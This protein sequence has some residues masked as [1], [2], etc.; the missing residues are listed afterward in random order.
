MTHALITVDEQS[1][2]VPIDFEQSAASNKDVSRRTGKDWVTATAEFQHRTYRLSKKWPDDDVA[3]W[4]PAAAA[5]ATTTS[6]KSPAA[7]I[8]TRTARSPSFRPVYYPIRLALEFYTGCWQGHATLRSV[9]VAS[10]VYGPNVTQLALPAFGQLLA[11][12]LTAPFFLFQM[13]CVV[14]WS[15]DEYW[16]YALYTLGAL[17]VFESTVAYNRLRGLERLRNAGHSGTDRVWVRR[18]TAVGEESDEAGGKYPAALWVPVLSK[19]LVPGDIVSLS[20]G[21]TIPADI[22]L[23]QGSGV[24]DEAPLTGESTPQL[25]HELESEAPT[26]A[27]LAPPPAPPHPAPTPKLDLQDAAHKESVLFGGT[28]LLAVTATLGESEDGPAASIEERRFPSLP[29]QGLVGMVVRTGFETS[30]GSLL[31]TLSSSSRKSD[32]VHTFDAFAFILGLVVCALAAAGWVWREAYGDERRNPFRLLLHLIILITSV[33]PPEL[34]MELSLAVTNSVAAL[35]QRHAVYCTE[36]FRIPLA[37]QVNV[38]C[39]DKT[40]TITSDEMRLRGVRLI[41]K[42]TTQPQPPIASSSGISLSPALDSST[43]DDKL[44]L[45]VSSDES[46]GESAL[47]PWSTLRVMA[48][49]HALAVG[50]GTVR[51]GTRKSRAPRFIGDPLEVAVLKHTGF[52]LVGNDLVTPTSRVPLPAEAKSLSILHRFSFSSKLKRMTTLVVEGNGQ[53]GS[54]WALCKG[55]PETVKLLLKRSS[56]PKNYDVISLYHMSRGRRVLSM[57]YKKL[58]NARD[59][60]NY[61]NSGRNT[62]ERDLVFAG[63]LIFDCPLKPESKAVISELRKSGQRV[64]MITGDALL[65]AAE[66]ARQVGIIG[67]AAGGKRLYQIQRRERTEKLASDDVLKDFECVSVLP[68]PGEMP[69]LELSR[70]DLPRLIAMERDGQATFCVSGEV[71]TNISV[72][73]ARRGSPFSGI[74]S[75]DERHHLMHPN[76]LSVL[77]SIVPMISVYARH[78]PHQKEA[79]VAAY[80]RGGFITCMCGDGTNDVGALKR[81]HV[82]ISIVN[83]PDAESKQRNATEKLKLAKQ[84]G[85]ANRTKVAE[86]MRELRDAQE[87]LDCVELG[88]ASVAAPFTSRQVSIKCC[89]DVIQQGRCTLVSMLSIYKI[90]GVNCLVNAMVLSKLFLHGAKQGERQLTILGI[91]V[92]ALFYFVTRAEPLP[93]LS[94]IRPPSS[95]LC[96]E[97]LLSIMGQLV[98]HT[99]ATLIATDAALAFADSYDPSLTP[100][101]SFNPNALNS[102][103]F[104]LTGLASIN[105]FAVNY[106]GRPFMADLKSNRLLYRTLQVCYGTL[107]ACALEVFPPLNDLLQLAS[108]AT[109]SSR[110]AG[111]W[112]SAPITNTMLVQVVQVIDFPAFLSLLM[113]IDTVIVF[114]LELYLVTVFEERRKS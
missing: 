2:I 112:L 30:Q 88:D 19:E 48:A 31:R 55:A 58:D 107:F 32:G 14:L 87:Q 24:V 40:G 100:D 34:P 10:R 21:S 38:C 68:A 79:I 36:P 70:S 49:C 73:S 18:G 89:K 46:S 26:L 99:A 103:T 1:G 93:T 9:Q 110:K 82:G 3:L 105:T 69:S 96:A 86:S 61:K 92:A 37:G 84:D 63:F 4:M 71:L 64:V 6:V 50:R 11:E 43:E 59:L 7:V 81:A 33:V 20:S 74:P 77:E 65:T 113:L 109:V 52:E 41:T 22:V 23:L 90:L 8:E 27:G 114:A 51:H 60:V 62:V 104:L 57:A 53:N 67:K 91:A 83:A 102:C 42:T 108:L 25:K 76:T 54:L 66:V 72:A 13:L 39:L 15:L 44:I 35:M 94:P 12:Q 28:T 75:K 16:I 5:T 29:N 80:N 95:I 101:G 56:V 111:H 78:A 85:A 106:R 45:P 98:V 17:L 97:A 47:L